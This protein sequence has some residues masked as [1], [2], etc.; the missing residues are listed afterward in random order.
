VWVVDTEVSV[1]VSSEW[2]V[3]SV[4]VMM[5]VVSVV[6]VVSVSADVVV[7]EDRL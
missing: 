3:W 7:V 5:V 6:W 1:L 2:V 4:V